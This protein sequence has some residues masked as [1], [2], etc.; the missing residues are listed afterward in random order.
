M[1]SFKKIA[2]GTT[3]VAATSFTVA[4]GQHIVNTIASHM[5]NAVV[6]ARHSNIPEAQARSDVGKMAAFVTTD[7]KLSAYFESAI[8]TA[9]H[10]SFN[11]S[12][13]SAYLT[14]I[15]SVLSSVTRKPDFYN[16]VKSARHA[17]NDYDL[18]AIAAAG[19]KEFGHIATPLYKKITSVASNDPGVSNLIGSLSND[20]FAIATKVLLNGGLGYESFQV[21]LEGE[22][23]Q[24]IADLTN[25]WFQEENA[26]NAN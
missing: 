25:Q 1:V 21:D 16:V 7:N 10:S 14:S 9:E 20:A 8:Q 3:V 6:A 17:V 13:V 22:A 5:S 18:S 15:G 24:L 2:A 26:N 12:I 11:P 19:E 4:N 23:K